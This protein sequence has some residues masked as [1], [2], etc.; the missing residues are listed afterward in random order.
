M[1]LVLSMKEFCYD[2]GIV[3]KENILV[4]LEFKGM[5]GRFWERDGMG[6]KVCEREGYYWWE[7]YVC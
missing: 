6:G 5:G 2:F 3:I 7:G 1:Y 4:T